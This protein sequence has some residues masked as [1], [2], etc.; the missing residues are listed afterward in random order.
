MN[1]TTRWVLGG[2]VAL[3]VAG[4]AY[5]LPA[6]AAES[7]VPFGPGRMGFHAGM[8]SGDMSAM[9]N[10]MAPLMAQMGTMHQ[11]VMGDVAAL[12]G[13]SVEELDQAMADGK[14]LT[15]LAEEKKVAIGE[16]RAVMT[17]AMK[18]LL[19]AQVEAGTITQAQAA[20]MLAM[21]EQNFGSCSSGGG[22]MGG[23]MQGMM[24]GYRSSY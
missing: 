4:A 5:V 7:S 11:T 1:G 15:A 24:Q 2:I 19:D 16:I 10:Q 21:H 12:L 18:S 9:H 8:M 3:A 23:G 17:K 14:S 13:M 22:M 6:M 20:Q